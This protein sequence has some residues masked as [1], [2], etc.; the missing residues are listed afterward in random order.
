MSGCEANFCNFCTETSRFTILAKEPFALAV[1]NGGIY[2]PDFLCIGGDG[3]VC[4]V[5]V[6]SRN[7]LPNEDAAW[8]KFLDA[9]R[10]NPQISFLWVRPDGAGGFNMTK[11][12]AGECESL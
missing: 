8:D 12:R 9:S 4:L 11:A 3:E 6:K 1:R 5:E 2:T 7:A 10:R